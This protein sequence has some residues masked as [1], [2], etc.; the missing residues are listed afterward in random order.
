ML[1]AF[2]SGRAHS[3]YSA[4]AAAHVISDSVRPVSGYTQQTPASDP[5]VAPQSFA[6]SNIA[7]LSV[8]GGKAEAAEYLGRKAVR[9]TSP[10]EDSDIF[11]YVN[12]SAIQ[13]GVIEVD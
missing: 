2:C 5:S 13:D 1:G 6:L 4:N 8:A 12:G 11:A 7:A 10:S 3:P 9:L